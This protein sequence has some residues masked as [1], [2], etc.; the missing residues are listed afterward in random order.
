M[1]RF[2]NIRFSQLTYMLVILMVLLSYS[3]TKDPLG[4][5]KST[6]PI[7]TEIRDLDY[8]NA[9]LLTHNIDVTFIETS[10]QSE[11]RIEIT[12]GKNLLEKIRTEIEQYVLI[13]PGDTITN[14]PSIV[15]TLERITISSDNQCNW[16]R[17]YEKPIEAKVYYSE[18]RHMEYR[19]IGNV[20][21]Q[22]TIRVNNFRIDIHEGSGNIDLLLNTNNSFLAFHYGTAELI[23]SGFSNINYL[24]QASFGR[25]H[26]EDLITD[27]TYMENRS[28]NDTYVY[29]ISHLGVTISATGNVYYG[30]NPPSISLNRNGSG[31]L[32]QLD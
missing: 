9:V 8:F 11:H 22:D 27:F 7:S 32:I 12:A 24:Y 25:I 30:G 4:C 23:A 3:C 1:H 15:D 31:R 26:A 29:A 28:T 6:G 2:I 5:I 19:S 21:F 17:S 20:I 13:I 18:I 16:V 14:T 10:D